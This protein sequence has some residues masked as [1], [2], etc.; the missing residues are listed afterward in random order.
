MR[1]VAELKRQ[2]ALDR[3]QL[4]QAQEKLSRAKV[5]NQRLHQDISCAHTH[6][7]LVKERLE[8]QRGIISRIKAAQAEVRHVASQQTGFGFTSLLGHV[9]CSGLLPQ[10]R[11]SLPSFSE[12]LAWFSIF[13]VVL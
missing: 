2:L 8:L 12:S 3:D 7:P 13:F 5:L 1:D 9:F 4:D 6:I 11:D 10:V